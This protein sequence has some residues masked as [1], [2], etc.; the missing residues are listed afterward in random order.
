MW[1]YFLKHK[2]AA[3]VVFQEFKALVE[4][5]HGKCIKTLIIDIVGEYT[6]NEFIEYLYKQG[7]QH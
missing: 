4:K 2:S 1:V 7:I 6:K 3:Y 5:E